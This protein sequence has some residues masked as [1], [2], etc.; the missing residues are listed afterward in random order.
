MWCTGYGYSFPFLDGSGLLTAPTLERVH[1]LY[2]QLF[3]VDHP[4]LSFIGLP[5]RR[6]FQDLDVGYDMSSDVKDE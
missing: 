4:S 1:P 5:Q 6:V 2:E 3:H